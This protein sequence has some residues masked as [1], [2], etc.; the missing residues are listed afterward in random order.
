ML[1]AI[2]PPTLAPTPATSPSMHTTSCHFVL[3]IYSRAAS[4]YL[5]CSFPGDLLEHK[6]VWWVGEAGYQSLGRVPPCQPSQMPERD[7]DEGSWTVPV[8]GTVILC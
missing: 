3:C 2:I 6:G 5:V 4:D 1:H 8:P 7:M